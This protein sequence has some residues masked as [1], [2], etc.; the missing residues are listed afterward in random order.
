MAVG[1]GSTNRAWVTAS[2]VLKEDELTI[3]PTELCKA[4]A[5]IISE[6]SH[7]CAGGADR[8]SRFLY[9]RNK[10]TKSSASY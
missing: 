3:M 7:I 1:W 10:I 6:E 5:D 9:R 2:P 8:V 4:Y